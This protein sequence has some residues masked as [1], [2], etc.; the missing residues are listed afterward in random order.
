MSESQFARASRPP[1]DTA[2]LIA[3][4][5]A[6]RRPQRRRIPGAMVVQTKLWGTLHET[7]EYR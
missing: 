4:R 3:A 2:T 1:A 5:A 6:C 7:L